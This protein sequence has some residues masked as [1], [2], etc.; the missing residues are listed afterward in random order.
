MREIKKEK[1]RTRVKDGI[2]YL[3]PDPVVIHMSPKVQD[4]IMK[5][6]QMIETKLSKIA[7]DRGDETLQDSR[8][9]DID[10]EFEAD[11]RRT[12]YELMEEEI[13]ENV[14]VK[15]ET[16]NAERE[17][18]ISNSPERS[19]PEPTQVEKIKNLLNEANDLMEALKGKAQ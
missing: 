2:E 10:D 17:E 7:Q 18:G 8:D 6:E 14:V 5:V 19:E 9:F 12:G 3:D 4:R 1:R 15:S 11:V 16:V 13:P